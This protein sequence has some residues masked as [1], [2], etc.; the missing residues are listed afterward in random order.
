[1]R[2][3]FFRS[4][5]LFLLASSLTFSHAQESPEAAKVR[6]LEMKLMEAYKQRQIDV[7]APLL[8]D[9]FV[10]TFEDGTVYGKTGYLSY[11]AST[12]VRVDAVDMSDLKIRMRSDTAIVT[13]AYHEKGETKGQPYDDHDRFTDVWQKKEGKWRMIASHYGIPVKP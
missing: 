1:M 13:G 6:A 8:D 2:P 4:L 9:D 12:S 11:A 5:T 3:T 10:I 7:F